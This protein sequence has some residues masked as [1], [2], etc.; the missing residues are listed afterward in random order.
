MHIAQTQLI[1]LLQSK[2]PIVICVLLAVSMVGCN[3]QRYKP[4]KWRAAAR[5]SKE[6]QT[7]IGTSN[8]WTSLPG[9]NSANVWGTL[10]GRKGAGTLP[11]RNGTS[12]PDR[13]RRWSPMGGTLPARQ[14]G[15]LP[16][17]GNFG[18]LPERRWQKL[19]ARGAM[20]TL[21]QRKPMGTLPRRRKTYEIS[22]ETKSVSTNAGTK[23]APLKRDWRALPSRENLRI[24]ISEDFK[25]P[26][27]PLRK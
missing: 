2:L 12:L 3:Q 9:R 23:L 8:S 13:S 27:N 19:P 1:R 17:R 24:P 21:P 25:L 11:F 7:E 6:K 4:A 5:K 15:T 14:M 20:G 22:T 18:T 10:P 16:Q 26:E